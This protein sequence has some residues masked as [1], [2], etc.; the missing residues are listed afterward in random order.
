MVAS[1]F[2]TTTMNAVLNNLFGQTASPT[3]ATHYI[4][5]CATVDKAGSVT[6]E[7]SGGSYAAVTVDNNHTTWT[8][9]STETLQNDIAF[10][11]PAAT[12]DWGTVSMFFI[13]NHGTNTGSAVLAYGTLTVAKAI[14]SGDTASFA[15]GDLDVTMVV[16]T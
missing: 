2:S 16:T 9:A 6:G 12:G 7:P 10:T 8:T 13:A 4:R 11:F 1:G 3:T 14:S 15:I 5:L